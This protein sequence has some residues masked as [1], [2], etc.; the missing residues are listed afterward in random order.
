MRFLAAFA[1][2]AVVMFAAA[3]AQASDEVVQ[4][5][6]AA[7]AGVTP[8][9][10]SIALGD[11]TDGREHERTWLGAIRW[12]FGNAAKVLHTQVPVSD[13]VGAAVR[14]GLAARNLTAGQ[15]PRYRLNVHVAQFDCNQYARRE[16]HIQLQLRL[17]DA[18]SGALVHEHNV[19]VEQVEGSMLNL[20]TGM[21]ASP[22]QLRALANTVLQSAVD[23]AL[24][25]AEFR[26]AL[27]RATA[28]MAAASSGAP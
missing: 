21:F 20:G 17:V 8:G 25:N 24:D 16:A 23:Q 27:S 2:A 26:A 14:D 18:V 19:N 13:V 28:P 10:P 12:G 11:V 4:L 1:L 5:T 7:P 6:Y 22:E 15:A 9:E 3:P